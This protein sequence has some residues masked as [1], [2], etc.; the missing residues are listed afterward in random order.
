MHFCSEDT[1]TFVTRVNAGILDIQTQRKTNKSRLVIELEEPGKHQTLIPVEELLSLIKLRSDQYVLFFNS[2]L[3]FST[4]QSTCSPS[5]WMETSGR[6]WRRSSTPTMATVLYCGVWSKFLFNPGVFIVHCTSTQ[7]HS[8]SDSSTARRT[9]SLVLITDF[10]CFSSGPA[11]KCTSNVA[12]HIGRNTQVKCVCQL[13]ACYR[14]QEHD[15][16]AS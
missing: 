14:S 7:Q 15:R 8:F 9:K 16:V 4:D 5:R 13:R 11:S 10:M 2:N 6:C 12:C 3:L 1:R